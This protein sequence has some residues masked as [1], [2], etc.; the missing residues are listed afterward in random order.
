MR[1]C[2]WS[3]GSP[4]WPSLST[5]ETRRPTDPRARRHRPSLRRAA[6]A[7]N[8]PGDAS[9]DGARRGLVSPTVMTP[10]AP[11]A[12]VAPRDAATDAPRTPRDAC[13]EV[14]HAVQLER[15]RRR[16]EG[17]CGVSRARRGGGENPCRGR[18]SNARR[19]DRVAPRIAPRRR[20]LLRRA[21]R[22]PSTCAVSR[23]ARR[24]RARAS[25]RS[26]AF[27]GRTT[28]C[29]ASRWPTPTRR[30]ASRQGPRSTW[31][32]RAD[33]VADPRRERPRSELLAIARLAGRH[34]MRA[35]RCL[36]GPQPD[37]VTAVRA[38][39][40]PSTVESVLLRGLEEREGTPAEP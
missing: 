38:M 29:G 9:D 6:R 39:H 37:S 13:D 26:I 18:H 4:R 16:D 34:F 8:G 23:E 36:P 1:H 7:L 40:L 27:S 3:R 21:P 5:A 2:W 28:P 35:C 32:P 19:R 25:R 31:S 17:L 22:L 30:D 24:T 14:I 20:D 15:R 11:T 33:S 12:N 10:S